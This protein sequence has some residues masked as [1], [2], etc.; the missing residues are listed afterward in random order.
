[1]RKIQ[2]FV[3]TLVLVATTSV[4][5][6]SKKHEVQID[7]EKK[8]VTVTL[9]KSGTWKGGASEGPKKPDAAKTESDRRQEQQD[10]SGQLFIRK[11][12]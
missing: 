12:F 7:K 2:A 4:F 1:M 5:A 6:Q 9:D 8:E 10:K 3:C 11:T